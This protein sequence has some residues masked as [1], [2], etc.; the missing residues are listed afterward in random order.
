MIWPKIVLTPIFSESLIGR[1]SRGFVHRFMDPMRREVRKKGRSMSYDPK[2]I[3]NFFIRK[4]REN[5]SAITPMQLQKLVYISHGW[6]LGLFGEPM[7]DEPF[8][9][10]DYGP[11]C[12]SLYHHFKSYG[13]T[14][15]RQLAPIE[16]WR[17]ASQGDRNTAI[18]LGFVWKHYG[19]MHGVKLSKLTHADGTPWEVTRK[20]TNGK[21]HAKIPNTLIG[22]HYR[23]LG[24]KLGLQIEMEPGP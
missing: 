10:W 19:D 5:G 24:E 7:I 12:T 22:D 4:A 6:H 9:A 14:P 11:V 15:I 3:A 18:V 2:A 13:S 23:L 1:L 21:R 17:E 8:E 16:P 20:S